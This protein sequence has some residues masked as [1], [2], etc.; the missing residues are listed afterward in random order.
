M[1][2]CSRASLA[3]TK[4][5]DTKHDPYLME[6]EMGL[7]RLDKG[8]CKLLPVLIGRWAEVGGD[9]DD[10][11]ETVLMPFKVRFSLSFFSF[12]NDSYQRDRTA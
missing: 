5:A 11:K 7:S 10:E 9:N 2:F 6:M 8:E 4:K 1:A 12:L 3:N